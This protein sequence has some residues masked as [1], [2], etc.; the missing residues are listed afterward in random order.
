MK[1]ETS[2]SSTPD[3]SSAAAVALRDLELLELGV[4]VDADR[5]PVAVLAVQR[6]QVEPLVDEVQQRHRDDER[7]AALDARLQARSVGRLVPILTHVHVNDGA[8]PN[9]W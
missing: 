3:S 1:R 8:R 9:L 7:P 4:L 6:H 5:E 2:S